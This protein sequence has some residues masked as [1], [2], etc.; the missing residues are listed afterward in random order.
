MNTPR[1]TN[2]HT[3]RESVETA[4]ARFKQI[5]GMTTWKDVRWIRAEVDHHT[6]LMVVGEAHNELHVAHFPQITCGSAG[7]NVE[8]ISQ[9]IHEAGLSPQSDIATALAT[10]DHINVSK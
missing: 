5:K 9:I 4:C 3:Y 6:G 1:I 8:V 10:A 2:R 7:V